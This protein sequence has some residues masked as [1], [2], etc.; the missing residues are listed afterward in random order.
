MMA[1]R[2]GQ[3]ERKCSFQQ[4][5]GPSCERWVTQPSV[6][7]NHLY[8]HHSLISLV[9]LFRLVQRNGFLFYSPWGELWRRRSCYGN[10][11]V[12]VYDGCPWRNG[13]WREGMS[14]W[15]RNGKRKWWR[16]GG[17]RDSKGPSRSRNKPT[18]TSLPLSRSCT[19]IRAPLPLDAPA[20]RR[21][22][23][24]F[25]RRPMLLPSLPRWFLHKIWPRS[26]STQTIVLPHYNGSA[27]NFR[28]KKSSLHNGPRLDGIWRVIKRNQRERDER[29]KNKLI[30]Q[31]PW[32]RALANAK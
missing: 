17:Q 19:T 29:E 24:T 22:P 10:P 14:R 20:K 13:T 21:A 30:H 32:Q 1:Q 15:E 9:Y 3:H 8:C 27:G 25:T 28:K 31:G 7:Q 6:V 18:E 4:I 5:R 23:P 11:G 12:C 2:T 16:R 26:A